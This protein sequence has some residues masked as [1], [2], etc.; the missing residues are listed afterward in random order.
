MTDELYAGDVAPREAWEILENDAEAIRCSL[1]H[2][3]V[4]PRFTAG[5]SSKNSKETPK[6]TPLRRVFF[7]TACTAAFQINNYSLNDGEPS[8]R[9]H[10]MP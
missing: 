10:V 4:S 7:L 8:R 1:F 9:F 2:R 5:A 6:E 3:V